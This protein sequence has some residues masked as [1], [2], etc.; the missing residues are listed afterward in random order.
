MATAANLQKLHFISLIDRDP[1]KINVH[2]IYINYIMFCMRE[3][4]H[5]LYGIYINI[6]YSLGLYKTAS[7]HR[8]YKL[9][10]IIIIYKGD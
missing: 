7:Y 8:I 5:N 6:I 3:E 4:M 2:I 9:Y 10:V 1:L